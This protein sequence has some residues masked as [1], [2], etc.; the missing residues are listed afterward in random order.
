MWLSHR[1]K[2]SV[3]KTAINTTTSCVVECMLNNYSQ[4]MIIGTRMVNRNWFSKKIL[5]NT[6]NIYTN[7][8]AA[9]VVSNVQTVQTIFKL[10]RCCMSSGSA[11][12]PRLHW[13]E[14]FVDYANYSIWRFIWV[15]VLSAFNTPIFQRMRTKSCGWFGQ[16]PEWSLPTFRRSTYTQ[17][18]IYIPSNTHTHTWREKPCTGYMVGTNNF[19]F[20]VYFIDKMHMPDTT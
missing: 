5:T 17:T 2:S 15:C 12:K 10:M 19:V 14:G 3:V 16:G 4:S 20:S 6:L 8:W 18:Y 1:Y 7:Y 13:H 11:R 9:Q